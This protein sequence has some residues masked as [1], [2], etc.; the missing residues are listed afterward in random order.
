M[1]KSNVNNINGSGVKIVQCPEIFL[2]IYNK[3]LEIRN[4]FI[5]VCL[6]KKNPNT[7]NQPATL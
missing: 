2:L 1:F 5:S 4:I 7:T 3:K 6:G